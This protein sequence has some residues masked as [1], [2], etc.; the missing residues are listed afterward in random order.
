M[1]KGLL[2]LKKIIC[3]TLVLLLF[4]VPCVSFAAEQKGSLRVVVKDRNQVPVAG[5]EIFLYAVASPAGTLNADFVKAG[6]SREQLM[7]EKYNRS[8]AKT[9]YAYANKIEG[10]TGEKRTTDS[11]GAAHYTGLQKGIYLVGIP[12]REGVDFNPFLLHVP[13]VINGVEEFYLMA[14]PKVVVPGGGGGSGSEQPEQPEQPPA[15]IEDPDIPLGDME[16]PDIPEVKEDEVLG[17]EDVKEDEKNDGSLILEVEKI[18]PQTGV[19][20][21]PIWL[22]NGCGAV[23]ILCGIILLHRNSEDDFD[24]EECDADA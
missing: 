4:S 10:I 20:R 12:E 19:T 8:S 11:T 21:F 16:Q 18:I 5:V 1:N 14:L 7:A 13:T 22:L 3:L 6:V 9:L 2:N 23:C 24:E 17:T 15:D